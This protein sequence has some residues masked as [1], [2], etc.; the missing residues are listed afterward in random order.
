MRNS[1]QYYLKLISRI[2]S[3]EANMEKPNG[4]YPATELSFWVRDNA[5]GVF[6]L[7]KDGENFDVLGSSE[8]DMKSV[9]LKFLEKYTE[10]WFLFLYALSPARLY[11][12]ECEWYHRYRPANTLDHPKAPH[13][14]LAFRCPVPECQFHC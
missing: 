7:S 5:S 12:L 8:Q 1:F 10:H 14:E 6:M 11:Y 3:A 13:S 2:L 9:I 4:P